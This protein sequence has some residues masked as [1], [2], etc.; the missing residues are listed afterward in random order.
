MEEVFFDISCS[1]NSYK[2]SSLMSCLQNVCPAENF[3]LLVINQAVFLTQKSRV[4][5]NWKLQKLLAQEA[6][7]PRTDRIILDAHGI[8]MYAELHQYDRTS[9]LVITFIRWVCIY[10]K[11][12]KDLNCLQFVTLVLV[13]QSFHS[14]LR[15]PISVNLCLLDQIKWYVCVLH[16]SYFKSINHQPR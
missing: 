13:R 12:S 16:S 15:F 14:F 2:C 3:L 11:S 8:T 7:L 10:S 9:N 4:Q 5:Q 6:Q 1:I